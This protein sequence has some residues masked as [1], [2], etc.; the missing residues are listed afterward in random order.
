VGVPHYWLRTPL[1]EQGSM[2]GR[3]DS[4]LDRKRR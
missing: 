4:V 1:V 2:N 3:F